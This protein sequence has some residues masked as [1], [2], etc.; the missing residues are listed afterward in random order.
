MERGLIGHR[1][2]SVVSV[3]EMASNHEQEPAQTRLP[4]QVVVLAKEEANLQE[5]AA[6]SHA[7]VRR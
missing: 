2:W 4:H 1:G 3:V 6:L 5:S 7:Q